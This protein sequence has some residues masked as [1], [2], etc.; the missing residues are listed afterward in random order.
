MR[1]FSNFFEDRRMLIYVDPASNKFGLLGHLTRKGT[2]A[3]APAGTSISQYLNKTTTPINPDSFTGSNRFEIL[4]AAQG[5]SNIPVWGAVGA[6]S[7]HD[8]NSSS[9]NACLPRYSDLSPGMRAHIDK[10]GELPTYVGADGKV[11][12]DREAQIQRV[13]DYYAGP[14][15]G[16]MN[17]GGFSAERFANAGHDERMSMLREMRQQNDA[18]KAAKFEEDMRL[19]QERDAAKECNNNPAVQSGGDTTGKLIATGLCI[20]EKV[21]PMLF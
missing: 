13:V 2:L 14:E 4:S 21:L 1:Y 6:T 8:S 3:N 12:V 20:F 10:F 17:L 9:T 5:G 18:A 11:H 16:S 7:V 19:A 15:G